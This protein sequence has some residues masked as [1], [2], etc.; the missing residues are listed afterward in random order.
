MGNDKVLEHAYIS[1]HPNAKNWIQYEDFSFFRMQVV[2]VYFV[3]GFGV[4]GWVV[5]NDFLDASP[6][7]LAE[8]AQDI[9]QHMNEHHV[10]AMCRIVK[11]V[12]QLKATAARLTTLDRLGINLR[13]ETDDG[14]LGKRVAFAKPATQPDDVR[15][16]LISMSREIQG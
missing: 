6:D 11:N 2:D 9:M 12:F 14:V 16:Q 1:R 3:G 15:K 7:P 4:M 10:E 8:D 5:A 13:I